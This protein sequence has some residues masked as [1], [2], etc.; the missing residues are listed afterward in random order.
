MSEEKCK[1]NKNGS[2]LYYDVI[3]S[4]IQDIIHKVEKIRMSYGNMNIFKDLSKIIA[5]LENLQNG[6]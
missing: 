6:G 2:C 4:Q 5:D 1:F 3:E